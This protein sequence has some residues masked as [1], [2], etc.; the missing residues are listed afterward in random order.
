MKAFLFLS[1][2]LASVSVSTSSVAAVSVGGT[3]LVFNGNEKEASIT[4]SNSNK[5]IP[6]LIQ[7]WVDRGEHDKSKEGANKSLI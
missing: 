5:G 4:V 7:S 3:R 6:V 2:F 1:L